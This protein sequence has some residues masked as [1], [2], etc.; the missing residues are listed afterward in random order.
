MNP[1]SQFKMNS[2]TLHKKTN[3]NV[4]LSASIDSVDTTQN[5]NNFPVKPNHGKPNLAPKPP[6]LN[7]K[8]IFRFS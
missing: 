5:N 8:N 7:G 2:S 3:S 6:A 4:N 1:N